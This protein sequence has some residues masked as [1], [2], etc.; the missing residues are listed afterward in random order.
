[1]ETT[2]DASWC[3]RP[4]FSIVVMPLELFLVPW[5]TSIPCIIILCVHALVDEGGKS[6]NLWGAPCHANCRL[7]PLIPTTFVLSEYLTMVHFSY[8]SEGSFRPLELHRVISMRCVARICSGSPCRATCEPANHTLLLCI[9]QVK[10]MVLI[11]RNNLPLR[12]SD[13]QYYE[14]IV[15]LYSLLCGSTWA[16]YNDRSLRSPQV[17]SIR[18]AL[19]LYW[20]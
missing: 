6:S 20:S 17:L 18:H 19:D 10:R 7:F 15:L 16:L 9:D 8:V 14:F 3:R 4:Y 11:T 12:S 2:S 13:F 1:M 5:S